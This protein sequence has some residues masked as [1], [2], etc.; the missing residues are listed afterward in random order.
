MEI[1][2]HCAYEI[3]KFFLLCQNKKGDEKDYKRKYKCL[4]IASK[5]IDECIK[6]YEMKKNFDKINDKN[7]VP[8]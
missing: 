6:K 5:Q 2:P 3:D 4:S 7:M 8:N 1:P